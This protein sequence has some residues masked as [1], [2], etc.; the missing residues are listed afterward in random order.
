MWAN[1]TLNRSNIADKCEEIN[2]LFQNYEFCSL[3]RLLSSKQDSER[4][5]LGL[6]R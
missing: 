5:F 4:P 6:S 1:L 3:S 2:R